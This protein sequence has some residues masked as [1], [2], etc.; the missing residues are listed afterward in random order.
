MLKNVK[1]QAFL[2]TIIMTQHY[3]LEKYKT[4][5]VQKR[6]LDPSQQPLN[7]L[8]SCSLRHLFPFI[9]E[10]NSSHTT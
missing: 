3:D 8:M 5:T 10:I 7:D 2:L 9:Q 1:N 6:T 4:S